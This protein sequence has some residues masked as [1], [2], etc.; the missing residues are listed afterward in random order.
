MLHIIAYEKIAD[1]LQFARYLQFCRCVRPLVSTCPTTPQWCVPAQKQDEEAKLIAEQEARGHIAAAA[2]GA[3]AALQPPTPAPRPSPADR[4][5]SAAVASAAAA[6]HTTTAA[7]PPPAPSAPAGLP[8]SSPATHAQQQ[9][10]GAILTPSMR[11]LRDVYLDVRD[12]GKTAA[13]AVNETFERQFAVAA[14]VLRPHRLRPV[15]VPGD[16]H[17]CIY[18]ALIPILAFARGQQG[19]QPP[20]ATDCVW[21]DPSKMW[22]LRE[23][24]VKWSRNF[25]GD[26]DGPGA[27]GEHEYQ[28]MAW[29]SR[30]GLFRRWMITDPAGV[31]RSAALME[32]TEQFISSHG[33]A[34]EERMLEAKL[35]S[36]DAA[37]S[38]LFKEAMRQCGDVA[39]C[40]E[41]QIQVQECATGLPASPV[42][43]G[44]EW[45]LA[46]G[47]SCGVRVVSTS[48]A[49]FLSHN[50]GAYSV[51]LGNAKHD[52][53]ECVERSAAGAATQ[54]PKAQTFV[55]KSQRWPTSAV[56]FGVALPDGRNNHFLTAWPRDD[57]STAVAAQ[58]CY[59]SFRKSHT[60]RWWAG[61]VQDS[62][63]EGRARVCVCVHACARAAVLRPCT[64]TQP[65]FY[66]ALCK[67]KLDAAHTLGTLPGAC[68]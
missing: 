39:L 53:L 21:R 24:Q 30:V 52:A 7:S 57:A 13:G 19:G 41:I 36:A 60:S 14:A 1:S 32:S 45:V 33:Y 17:C 51:A 35:F 6:A 56:V 26:A 40:N 29:W 42:H 62:Q 28:R 54:A 67:C 20:R 9:V 27:P 22:D 44:D 43:A 15:D 37:A 5:P 64:T 31:E 46:L 59:A 38:D 63:G 12:N 10:G 49:N 47:V 66:N 61:Y 16:G 58:A 18:A 2:A 34:E 50:L 23:G 55:E 65:E 4:P 3:A 8:S 11:H 48:A 25:L 68:R